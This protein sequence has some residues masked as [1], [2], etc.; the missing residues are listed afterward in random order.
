[1]NAVLDNDLSVVDHS[2]AGP[3]EY[4]S[5]EEH[6]MIP[7]SSPSTANTNKQ[8][9]IVGPV[10]SLIDLFFQ[11]VTLP[12]RI[13]NRESLPFKIY[14][15]RRYGPSQVQFSE[16]DYLTSLSRAN[17]G[18]KFAMVYLHCESNED[19]DR[20]CDAFKSTEFSNFLNE[21]NV[22]VYAADVKSLNGY[23][24]KIILLV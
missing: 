11:I 16:D 12:L 22:L 24:S 17:E 20:F 15:E 2:A 19:S 6:P 18:S 9:S 10:F 13:L 23:Q 7:N 21:L 8:V 4:S 5:D 1:V 14:F 3:G